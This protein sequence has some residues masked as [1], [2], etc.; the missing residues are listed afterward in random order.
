MAYMTIES[1]RKK[2][3]DKVISYAIEGMHLDWYM[4]SP[5]VLK[6]YGRYF[7]YMELNKASQILAA[8]EGE[9]LMGVLF[10]QMYGEQPVCYSPFKAFYVKMFDVLQHLFAGKAVGEYDEA[11]QGMLRSYMK[12]SKPD[13]ELIF[14]AADPA[15]KGKGVGTLLLNELEQ[16]E[17]GKTIY[18]FTDSACTYQ[19]YEHRGF[20]RSRE[21]AIRLKLDKKEVDLVCYLYSKTLLKK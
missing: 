17:K 20:E 15:S 3:Y 19:F 14:F 9:K 16:R 12:S 5:F 1:L 2:D 6:A 4:S 21:K 10:A 18:L 8:Y 11:N 7:L 13:G